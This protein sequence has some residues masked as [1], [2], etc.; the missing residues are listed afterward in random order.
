M[1]LGKTVRDVLQKNEAQHHMLV[2]GGVQVPAQL[3][4]GGPEFGFQ[5]FLML[6][7]EE[8]GWREGC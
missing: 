6:Y 8:V 2:V 5:C 3:V 4:G 1:P 7:H